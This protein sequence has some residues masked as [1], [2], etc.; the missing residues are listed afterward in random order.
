M[1]SPEE[2]AYCRALEALTRRDYPAAISSFEK[3]GERFA[4]N[5][6]LQIMAQAARIICAVQEEKRL[7]EFIE[8]NIV[9]ALLNG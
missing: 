7:R 8:S 4:D 2:K 9:E 6:R 5:Q 1:L 3:C